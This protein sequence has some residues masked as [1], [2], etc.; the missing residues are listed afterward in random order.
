[1]SPEHADHRRA[2]RISTR[3][4]TAG[5][6][7]RPTGGTSVIEGS[8]ELRIPL[9]HR[10]DGAVFVDGAIVGNGSLQD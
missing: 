3:F 6:I 1:M 7:P 8:V 9:M 2:I 5:F 10:L 4:R